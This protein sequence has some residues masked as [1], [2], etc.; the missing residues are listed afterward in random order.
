MGLTFNWS[1]VLWTPGQCG[2]NNYACVNRT[3]GTPAGKYIARMCANRRTSDAG[4]F[5]NYD[6]VQTC[7]DVPFEYPTTT[8]VEGV[9]R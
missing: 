8:V 2:P 9:L 7:V 3:C 6:P 4:P 5:C 1:G